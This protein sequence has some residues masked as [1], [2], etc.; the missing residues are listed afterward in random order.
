MFLECLYQT[1]WLSWYEVTEKGDL[2]IPVSYK[3]EDPFSCCNPPT[4]L[5][6]RQ[7]EEQGQDGGF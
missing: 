5:L 7:K 2:G 6:L 1:Y 4:V 3:A